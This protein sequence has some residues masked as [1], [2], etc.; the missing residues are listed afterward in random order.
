ML[1]ASTSAVKFWGFEAAVTQIYKS[2]GGDKSDYNTLQQVGISFAGGYI[3]GIFCAIV[4]QYVTPPQ[5]QAR[6]P[7]WTSLLMRWLFVLQQPC[8]Y[9]GL[10][11]ERSPQGWSPCSYHGF[12]LQG[13]WIRRIVGW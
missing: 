2:L 13:H 12:H 3:A 6:P 1:V 5:S 7:D 4:S 9:H 8:R 11:V 10:Q